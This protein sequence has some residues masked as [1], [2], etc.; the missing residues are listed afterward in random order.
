MQEQH[1]RS[2]QAIDDMLKVELHRDGLTEGETRE[3]LQQDAERRE[4]I[5]SRKAAYIGWLVANRRFHEEADELRARWG[6]LVQELG[7]FPTFPRWPIFDLR[8]G[9]DVPREFWDFFVRFYARWG[10][11]PMP[12]WDWLVPMEPDLVGRMLWDRARLPE[13][14]VM[15]FVPW[16]LLRGERLDL[17][18][19][20]QQA[21]TA[22]EAEHLWDWLHKLPAATVRAD[23][24]DLRC[25]LRRF[26]YSQRGVFAEAWTASASEVPRR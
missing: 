20:V 5:E 16:Y 2:T 25:R 10:L 17:Q 11:D 26:M 4:V 3:Y 21:R 9:V 12:T 23:P 6:A 1:A 15:V 14:D 7:R 22:C 19:V 18:G 24:S 8:L 13:A